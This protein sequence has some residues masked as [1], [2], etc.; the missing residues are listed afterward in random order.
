MSHKKTKRQKNSLEIYNSIRKPLCPPTQ[1][2]RN[3]KAYNRK[4]KH[5]LDEN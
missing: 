1:R 4:Q 3:K 2:H 5:K